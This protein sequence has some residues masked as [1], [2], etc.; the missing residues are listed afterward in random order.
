MNAMPWP[1]LVVDI[2]HLVPSGET[3]ENAPRQ[4][5]REAEKDLRFWLPPR[6]RYK[7]RSSQKSGECHPARYDWQVRGAVVKAKGVWSLRWGHAAENTYKVIPIL[8]TH[9]RCSNV[10]SD[11]PCLD[12][13]STKGNA[14]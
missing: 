7:K 2:T 3:A 6:Q 11:D 12:K 10:K 9:Y 1:L 13:S 14:K 5:L 8:P 4:S